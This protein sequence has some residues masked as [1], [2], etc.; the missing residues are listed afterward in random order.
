MHIGYELFLEESSFNGVIDELSKG[1][2]QRYNGIKSEIKKRIDSFILDSGNLDGSKMQANWFPQISADVF[3]S[4]SHKDENLA[5]AFSQ[6]LN[7]NF[8]LYV[9]IDSCVWGYANELLKMIDDEY[10]LNPSKETYDY[11]KRNY[12]TSHV[13]MM[14]STALSMMIDKTECI[15]FLN[16]P[17]SI[18]PD[19]VISKTESPWIYS[20]IAMTKL[21]GLR[22]IKDHRKVKPQVLSEGGVIGF[23]RVEYEMDKKH[24]H[25]LTTD[26]LCKWQSEW[27]FKEEKYPTDHKQHALDL[28]YKITS[29]NN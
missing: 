25:Q 17:N 5:I 1:G 14:L 7:V 11:I 9:F 20:E 16:T 12:S 27:D 22:P 8:G 21:I 6:W 26:N 19:S 4:H 28:L 24:L 23:M 15:I 3:I 2:R 29:N 18:T 10:C 13:H